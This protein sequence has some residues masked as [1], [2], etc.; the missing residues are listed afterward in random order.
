[1]N[2][3]NRWDKVREWLGSRFA[4]LLLAA[5]SFGVWGAIGWQLSQFGGWGITAA[6]V[7]FVVQVALLFRA[8]DWGLRMFSCSAFGIM[9]WMAWGRQGW[10]GLWIAVLWAFL[11]QLLLT[12]TYT[13][14]SRPISHHSMRESLQSGACVEAMRGVSSRDLLRE[15]AS[16]KFPTTEV[17]KMLKPTPEASE[18]HPVD[19]TV[20]AP[21]RLGRDQSGLLQVFLH[22]PEDRI[23]AE[24]AA[25]KPDRAAV[26]RGHRS[27]VLDARIGTLF[28]FEV[29]IE[30]FE[31]KHPTET[32]LWTGSPQAAA[33]N[34]EVPRRCKWGQ[35]AGTVFVSK[36]GI[37]VG[38]ISFQIE[39][40]R[41]A[42]KVRPHPAGDEARHYRS[43]FCSY[44][45]LDRVEMLKREQG[46]RAAGLETFVDAVSLRPGDI[47]SPKIFEA[48]DESDLFVLIWSPNAR[49]SK[50]V[51]KETRYAMKRRERYRSPDFRPIPVEGPPIAPVPRSL[52]AFNFNDERLLLIRAA[53]LEAAERARREAQEQKLKD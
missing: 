10:L 40:V 45:T 25:K 6:V 50:W 3:N 42:T 26:E 23:M 51:Q 13:L 4:V 53:E 14:S 20:F 2:E 37:P 38:S 36:D 7:L 47:W 17:R 49:S 48:I 15:L 27:L 43:C 5:L 33:F 9:I 11:I 22:A 1:M 21:D 41:H 12:R 29:E 46:L 31:F 16:G 28:V 8:A 32:L 39:V 19:C 34:F 35:H 44:S 24:T 30:G 52:R 18:R